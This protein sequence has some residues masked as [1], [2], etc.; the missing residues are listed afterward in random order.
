MV[1]YGDTGTGGVTA[2]G[3]RLVTVEKTAPTPL[4]ATV[5]IWTVATP[6]VQTDGDVSDGVHIEAVC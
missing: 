5:R 4:K 2:V 6:P 1:S 3:V